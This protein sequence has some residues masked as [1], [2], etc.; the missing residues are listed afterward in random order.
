MNCSVNPAL[1]A[2]VRSAPSVGSPSSLI[3][4]SFSTMVDV[5]QSAPYNSTFCRL[6]CLSTWTSSPFKVKSPDGSYPVPEIFHVFPSAHTCV[7]VILF[8]V[9]V[10]VLSEQII[11]AQPSVSTA[12]SFL[13]MDFCFIIRCTPRESATVTIA[14]SPSGIAATARDT[15]AKNI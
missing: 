4:P 12:G 3:S 5:L 9:I 2:A 1:R 10:P 13:T 6:G 11:E 14:G 15:P 7:T 8:C